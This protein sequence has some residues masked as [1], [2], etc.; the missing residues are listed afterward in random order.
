MTTIPPAAATAA[1]EMVRPVASGAT[2][3][4]MHAA[5]G[6]SATLGIA[7]WADGHYSDKPDAHGHSPGRIDRGE[8][9]EMFSG[10]DGFPAIV[11]FTALLAASF[12][13]T[14]GREG[15]APKEFN[16]LRTSYEVLG[17][18]LVGTLLAPSLLRPL[19]AEFDPKPAAAGG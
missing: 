10:F 14:R 11:T 19:P 13:Y 12:L 8:A 1:T 17:G 15:L 16:M 6:A 5:V 7:L 4:L 18:A 3:L 2:R 9:R